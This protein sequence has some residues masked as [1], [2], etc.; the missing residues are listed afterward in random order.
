MSAVFNKIGVTSVS[1]ELLESVE[2]T[3]TVETK[4]IK[5][6]DGGFGQGKGSGAKIEY[7]VKGRG[8]TDVKVGASSGYLPSSIQGGVTI[9]TSVKISQKNDDYNDFEI[10]GVNYPDAQPMG[11]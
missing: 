6:T 9:V 3:K 1:G 11:A 5:A 7:T 10:S 4:M 2:V 8:A